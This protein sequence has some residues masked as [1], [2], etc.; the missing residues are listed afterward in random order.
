MMGKFYTKKDYQTIA[1]IYN[2]GRIAKLDYLHKGYQ[3][4]K[5][6]VETSLGKFVISKNTLSEKKDIISKSK[7]SL[8]YEIDMLSTLRGLPVPSFLKS[9]KGKFIEKFKH[10]WVTVYRFFPGESPKNITPAMAYSLGV[11]LGEFHKQGQKFKKIES[12]RRRFYYLSPAIIRNMEVVANKQKN[13]LLKS[14]IL[15]IKR[16]VENNRPRPDLPVGPIHVDI[17][18]QNEIFQGNK[19]SAIIDFGNFYVG[20]FMIDVGKTIMWNFCL[21]N[22]LDKTALREFIRGY[23]SKRKLSKNE[24]AYLEKSIL[25]AIY[26]H[27]WV[28]LYHTPLKYVP[29]SYTIYLVKHFLP[30]AKQIEKLLYGGA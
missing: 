26:S 7:K 18:A 3:S 24:N 21:R 23:N 19:L 20:P 30:I 10:D 25:Y 12:S 27:I 16:G 6:V 15:D 5:V 8:Q 1:N 13:S 28:D 2:L 9:V 29:E 4:P 14:V 22:K 11:F 17:K